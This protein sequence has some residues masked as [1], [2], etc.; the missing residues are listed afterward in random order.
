MRSLRYRRTVR[1]SMSCG[2]TVIISFVA[3]SCR[4]RRWRTSK[5]ARVAQLLPLPC[6]QCS[7]SSNIE[8]TRNFRS[9]DCFLANDQVLAFTVDCAT[10]SKVRDLDYAVGDKGAPSRRRRWCSAGRLNYTSMGLQPLDT[11]VLAMNNRARGCRR[12][13]SMLMLR[14]VAVQLECSCGPQIRDQL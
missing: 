13:R 8:K 12:A 7:E 10:N 6:I 9:S 3:R 2:R 4:I 11:Q 1:K 14:R 5:T